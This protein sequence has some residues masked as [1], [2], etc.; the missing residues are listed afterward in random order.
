MMGMARL[1]AMSMAAKLAQANE[2]LVQS[3]KM[4]SIGQLAAMSGL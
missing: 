2:Q 3:E 1:S 4:A